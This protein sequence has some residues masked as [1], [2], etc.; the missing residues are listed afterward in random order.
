MTPYG[1]T[2]EKLIDEL[3]NWGLKHR[4]RIIEKAK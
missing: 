3:Q 2:L 4:K 1:R